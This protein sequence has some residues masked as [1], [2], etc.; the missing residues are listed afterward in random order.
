MSMQA[1]RNEKRT[2]DWDAFR[3]FVISLSL[4]IFVFSVVRSKL[5]EFEF[6][7]FEICDFIVV[8]DP[9]LEEIILVFLGSEKLENK[10]GF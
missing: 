5:F 10:R 6:L 7:K 2:L 4:W 1:Q 9:P 8:L 3:K